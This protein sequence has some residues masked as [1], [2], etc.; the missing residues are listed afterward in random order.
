MRNFIPNRFIKTSLVAA[1]STLAISMPA[2]ADDLEVFEAILNSQN[3]P[4][5]L[6]VLDYSGSMQRDVYDVEIPSTDTTTLSKIDILKTA[7]ESLLVEN[8]DSV[9]VGFG[10]FFNWRTSGIRWP[11][12][13][14]EANANLLDP[15]IPAADNVTNAEVIASQLSRE[16]PHSS[17]ATVNG[18][19]EAA[20]YFRGDDVLHSGYN[21][22]QPQ[23][24][25]P[26]VWN[27]L[28]RKYDSG[29]S[30]AAL[31]A[32][33]TPSTA[34]QAGVETAGQYGH[35]T[36]YFEGAQNCEGL[37]TYD[38]VDYDA[39][40]YTAMTSSSNDGVST[41]TSEE[42]TWT[43]TQ[44]THCK[45]QYPDSWST[46][47][48]VSPLKN[49]CQ[50]NFIVLISDGQPTGLRHTD[51]LAT[52][53]EAAGD[54]KGTPPGQRSVSDCED[55][56]LSVFQNS[57][58]TE[59]NCGP[60]ILEYLANN[61]IN[62]NIEN[63]N[64]KTFTVGFGI[65][66]PGKEYLELLASKGKGAFYEATQPA[67][68]TTALN[69]VIDSI[70][71]GSQNF[72]ELSV[73]VDP[74]TFSHDN[75][76]Y[77][78]LFSPSSKPA[79]NGNLKGFFVDGTGLIDINGNP[80]TF[81]D[82][83]GIQFSEESHSF[84]SSLPDGNEVAVGGASEGLTSI[85][86]TRNLYTYLEG[87][88]TNLA[89]NPK[90]QLNSGNADITA[91]M[92]GT[93]DA[94]RTESLDWIVS[95]PMGDP[96]HTKP[97]VVNY[98]ANKKVVFIMTNQ[99]FLH[100]FDA[101]KPDEPGMDPLDLSGGDEIFA[102]M[103]Q[104]LLSNLP[105]LHNNDSAVF[106]HIY[107]LDGGLTRWHDDLNKDGLVNGADTLTLVF[108][109][110]RGGGAYYALD[111][112]NPD[113]P[114]FLWKRDKFDSGF[115][116]LAQTWSRPAL[117]SVNNGGKLERMLMFGGGYDADVVDGTTQP[118]MA[119]G[120]AIFLVNKQGNLIWSIDETD[121][122]ASDMRYSIPS[123]LTVINSD[124]KNGA[125][126]VYF[127]DLA[128]QVWRVDFD[129][130]SSKADTTITKFADVYDGTNHR[131]IFYPPSVS[132]NKE[133]G[134]RFLAVAFGTGDRTQPLMEGTQNG[135]YMLKDKNPKVGAP[136]SIHHTIT[137]NTCT[138]PKPALSTTPCLYNATNNDIGSTVDTT[139]TNAS[140][141]MK[142]SDGWVFE[143]GAGEKALSQ[144]VAFEG[145]FMAT[146]FE[147]KKSL[148][149]NGDIDPCS[150]DMSGRLY[151]LDVADAQPKGDGPFEVL[152][153]TTIPSK[154]VVLLPANSDHAQIFVDKESVVA[155]NKDI[156]TVFWHAK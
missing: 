149:A 141:I 41:G 131:P 103:P 138:A 61:D 128:G 8:K 154:P 117:I 135:L 29:N 22:D 54:A 116:R 14:L 92:M 129:D 96:L 119:S 153:G 72:A 137:A 7:V 17:T 93:S 15:N 91:T 133:R 55:L 134:K 30:Y 118:T 40:T 32:T 25:K 69:N 45:Y 53:L 59:G 63:S 38:C 74:T 13:D 88:L 80:A 36:D 5:I 98:D 73:D 156:T 109:M 47:K 68:L 152:N 115:E 24:H 35:C 18:L 62:P 140:D 46:P 44:R 60:E 106:E 142:S 123:D 136:T 151:I 78:S 127:G 6:F 19:A 75:R 33:Y 27:T 112:T 105:K 66:G 113:Q 114:K 87:E 126:R 120:N 111:V 65:D 90:N 58:T 95:A 94:L 139:S 37:V 1:A 122:N 76:T 125:D 43:T 146:T 124:G 107:G 52:I 26:D 97:V 49:Q 34:Y 57:L 155:L 77:F 20:A 102:F 147:P 101:T 31:P 11:I 28:E 85:P 50:A 16:W 148:T 64:V 108:G 79:W 39:E 121:P 51:T 9:N 82:G 81:D 56:S 48:Y 2:T 130:I 10:S 99:G 143:L 100:A 71:A 83:S 86:S 84:W 110:R 132:L 150:F 70:L 4:N 67:E 144:V 23:F 42:V 145:Q 21:T 12:S 89:T 3:K 104:E